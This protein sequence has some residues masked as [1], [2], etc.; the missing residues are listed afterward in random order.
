MKYKDG[1]ATVLVSYFPQVDVNGETYLDEEGNGLGDLVDSE[2]NGREGGS[3]DF[4]NQGG[5][6]SETTEEEDEE[7][8]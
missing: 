4:E 6:D 7:D 3:I 1:S 5:N 8:E 2:D